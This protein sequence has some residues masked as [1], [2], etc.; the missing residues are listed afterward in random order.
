L[1]GPEESLSRVIVKLTHG[2][3]SFDLQHQLIAEDAERRK[4]KEKQISVPG[5]A[6]TPINIADVMPLG[7]AIHGKRHKLEVGRVA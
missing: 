4:R 6:I 5:P 2:D 7:L 3:I 1:A